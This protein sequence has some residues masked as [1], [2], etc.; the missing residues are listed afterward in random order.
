MEQDRIG[1][2]EFWGGLSEKGEKYANLLKEGLEKR[3]FELMEGVKIPLSV[4]R[5][6]LNEIGFNSDFWQAMATPNFLEYSSGGLKA[7]FNLDESEP[8]YLL[9][10]PDQ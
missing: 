4:V 10:E 7:E 8:Y 2:N 3:N 1:K 5:E 6:I 9:S